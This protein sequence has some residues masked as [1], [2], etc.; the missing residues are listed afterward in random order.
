[1]RSALVRRPIDV[2]ALIGEVSDATNGAISVF[3]GT[4]RSRNDGR[5]VL[6]IEYSA[7]ESMAEKEMG[8]ILSEAHE[9]FAVSHIALEHRLG[10][11]SIGDASVVIAAAHAHRAPAIDA[12]RFI[13]EEL[14]R[15]VPIW[16]LE[17]YADGS[18]D[19]VAATAVK[20]P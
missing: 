12:T 2:G 5:D 20:T 1:M 6:G 14:K 16:K 4:V 11:L 17:L 7:Y 9:K 15:R 10:E 3:V 19:W 13:I 8:D 18:R